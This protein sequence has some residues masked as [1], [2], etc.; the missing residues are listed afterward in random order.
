MEE[1]SFSELGGSSDIGNVSQI[2]PAIHPTGGILPPGQRI[3][4]HSHDFALAAKSEL[5]KVSMM[6][7]IQVL[8]MCGVDLLGNSNMLKAMKEEFQQNMRK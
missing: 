4:G 5:A 6:R 1:Q 2:V 7:G 8:A 3:P